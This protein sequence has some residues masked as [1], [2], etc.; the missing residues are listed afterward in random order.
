[1]VAREDRKVVTPG[2]VKVTRALLKFC[3]DH[4]LPSPFLSELE[5][6]LHA[7]EEKDIE[8][9]TRQA[10]ILGHAGMGSFLDWV[11]QVRFEHENQEYVDAVWNALLGHW[12][13]SMRVFRA[14]EA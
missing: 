1:L 3:R 5:A 14:T 2:R 13:S 9:V 7:L 10:K 6:C 11:P 8:V 12:L 4:D